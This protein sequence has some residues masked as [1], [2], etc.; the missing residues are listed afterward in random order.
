[1][2]EFYQEI[3]R[4]CG[5]EKGAQ[6]LADL[7]DHF[8]LAKK[9]NQCP[10]DMD[11]FKGIKYFMPCMLKVQP[12][13]GPDRELERVSGQPPVAVRQAATL[14]IVF[15]MGYVPPGFFVRVVARMTNNKRYTPLLDTVVH[16][17]SI[18]FRYKEIGYE[19]EIDRVTIA[20]SL[21]SIQVNVF[22]VS[23]RTRFSNRFIESCLSLR[24]ELSSMCKEVLDC[25]LPSIE[26]D[27]A[28]KCSCSDRAPEHFALL[29]PESH[30]ESRLFCKFDKEFKMSSLHK[31]W[32][33]SHDKVSFREFHKVCMFCHRY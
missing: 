8:D 20:E 24:N 5:L 31:L 30:Q 27:L 32:L 10:R 23:T 21:Q 15:N 18:T 6:A 11:Q 7:L 16:R 12:K 26:L 22:R 19:E 13:E 33:R 3:W 4:D 14:H 28:F 17:N 25:W 29:K 2:E 9:I 1:M